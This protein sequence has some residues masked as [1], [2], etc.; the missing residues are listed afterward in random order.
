M[1]LLIGSFVRWLIPSLVRFATNPSPFEGG[2]Q[3]DVVFVLIVRWFAR[4][5]VRSF[6]TL[7]Q[8]VTER[9]RSNHFFKQAFR[10]SLDGGLFNVK[11]S[12][13]VVILNERSERRIS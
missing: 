12:A 9:N 5:L 4:S 8:Q 11:I 2:P 7:N 6:A 13:S 1:S 10:H 3:G